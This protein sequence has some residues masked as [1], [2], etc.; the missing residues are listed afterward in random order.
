MLVEINETLKEGVVVAYIKNGKTHFKIVSHEDY[1]G[2]LNKSLKDLKSSLE[3]PLTQ[4]ATIVK[5]KPVEVVNSYKE[6]MF[7]LCKVAAFQNLKDAMTFKGVELSDE[8]IEKIYDFVYN[9]SDKECP[10]AF[11]PYLEKLTPV[12]L[13]STNQEEI[14]EN[15]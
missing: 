13:K 15:E 3:K 6:K 9:E 4:I 11:I 7:K 1:L 2:N 14:V 12:S 10:K 5:E 8:E